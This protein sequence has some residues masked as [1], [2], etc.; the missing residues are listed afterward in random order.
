MES[1]IFYYDQGGQFFRSQP[2]MSLLAHHFIQSF[3]LRMTLHGA[4]HSGSV[5]RVLRLRIEKLLVSDSPLEELLCC[6]L[7]QDIL[8][9]A[10][11]S[12]VVECFTGDGGAVCSSLFGFTTLCP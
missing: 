12:A 9:A 2:I 5:G 8:S 3:V 10:L 11:G 6:V 1:T 4:E 7:E